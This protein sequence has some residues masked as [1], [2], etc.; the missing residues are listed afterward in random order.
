MGY[1]IMKKQSIL[2]MEQMILIELQFDLSFVSPLKF[3]DLLCLKYGLAAS[4]KQHIYH[5]C[6]ATITRDELICIKPSLIALSCLS[7]VRPE[8][9]LFC[10]SNSA[11]RR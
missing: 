8:L 6:K 4:T 3:V 11:V 5:M 9:Q 1:Q 10:Q 2:E 7:I